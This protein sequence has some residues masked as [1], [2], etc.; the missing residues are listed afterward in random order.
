M[1]EPAAPNPGSPSPKALPVKPD[2]VEKID[3][4]GKVIP[5]ASLLTSACPP[6]A[7][8]IAFVT[9]P[10]VPDP[11]LII[12]ALLPVTDNPNTSKP[13][14]PAPALIVSVLPLAPA[15]NDGVVV[16]IILS[17]EIVWAGILVTVGVELLSKVST[18]PGSG[19]V[20]V[21][22]QFPAQVQSVFNGP[23]QAILF[24]VQM[25]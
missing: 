7:R 12:S 8:L 17:F 4:L 1:T 13:V 6:P 23:G 20:R 9:L 11:S 22:D 10:S 2:C 21:G 5:P 14:T 3:P 19:V 18:S 24:G 15:L 25:Y 16:P